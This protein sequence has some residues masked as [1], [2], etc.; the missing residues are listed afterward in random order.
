[1]N[2]QK[3]LFGILALFMLSI[4]YV[5]CSVTKVDGIKRLNNEQFKKLMNK[6]GYVVLD[7]RTPREFDSA[8]IK[9]AVLMDYL[10]TANFKSSILNLDPQKKYLLYCRTGKRS[11]NA[12]RML[13]EIGCYNVYDL[14][15]GIKGWDGPTI[16]GKKE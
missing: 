10:D 14:Q 16:S 12:A 1:M 15:N 7:V 9:G 11:M 2:T 4:T 13:K 5:Q 3:T 8:R 6:E